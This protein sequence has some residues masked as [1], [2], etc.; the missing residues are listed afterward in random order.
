[1]LLSVLLNFYF[2]G[3]IEEWLSTLNVIS[4]CWLERKTRY[5]LLIYGF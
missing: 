2:F 3:E 4:V 5:I 1:M